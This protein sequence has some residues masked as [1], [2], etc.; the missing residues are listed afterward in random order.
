M[1]NAIRLLIRHVP[2]KRHT[3]APSLK[4]SVYTCCLVKVILLALVP[5]IFLPVGLI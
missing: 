3:Y 2:V 4:Q 1:I 5:R